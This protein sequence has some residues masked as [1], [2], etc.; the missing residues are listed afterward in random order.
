L[1]LVLVHG[2]GPHDQ[3]ETVGGNK[4]FRDLA[5]GLASRGIAVLRYEKRTKKYPQ[6][7]P[8]ADWT[9]ED[10]VI[11]DAVAAAELLRQHQ[12]IDPQ[13]VYVLGHSLGGTLAPYIARRDGKLAGIVVMA[14][15][16]RSILDLLEEQTEYL[17]KLNGEPSEKD[18]QD[19][20]KLKQ[21]LAAIRAGKTQ[22]VTEPILGVP[23]AYWERLHKLDPTATAVTLQIPILILQ[24]GRDYQ[25]TTKD[26]ALWQERLGSHKNVTCKLFDDLN[27]L[28][29]AGQGFS[30]PAEYQQAG[31]VDAKVIEAIVR[32]TT[33]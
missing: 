6:A 1:A 21:Q 28:F 12:D 18:R 32:W 30:K 3:D 7:R 22:E 23:A 16:A 17:S 13:R 4:P 31:H 8:A 20:D 19:L 15:S 29:I 11:D 2:S 26:F 14:G 33:P 27:H 5:W 24:G 25:V 10:E 9:L